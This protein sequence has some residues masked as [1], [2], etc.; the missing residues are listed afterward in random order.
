MTEDKKKT[1]QTREE[2]LDSFSANGLQMMYDGVAKALKEDDA[3]PADKK[4]YKVR[5]EPVW[6]IW[7]AELE[8]ALERKKASYVKIHWEK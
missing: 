7:A 4:K 2:W 6:K 3:V 1:V 8:A 5:E